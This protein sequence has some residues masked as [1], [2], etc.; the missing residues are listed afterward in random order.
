MTAW[1]A[2]FGLTIIIYILAAVL[3]GLGAFVFAA[4]FLIAA[5]LSTPEPQ[6]TVLSEAQF[7]ALSRLVQ[8][9]IREAPAVPADEI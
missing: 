1:L 4:L 6:E 2:R 8:R 7:R 5:L 9:A 3:A